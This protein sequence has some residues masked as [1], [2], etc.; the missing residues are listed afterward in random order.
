MPLNWLLS[1]LAAGATFIAAN[2]V[3]AAAVTVAGVL[4]GATKRWLPRRTAEMAG[5]TG[6]SFITGRLFGDQITGSAWSIVTNGATA[7]ARQIPAVGDVL[8]GLL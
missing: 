1:G 3:L 7:T 6:V 8:G 2:P 4:I 5:V